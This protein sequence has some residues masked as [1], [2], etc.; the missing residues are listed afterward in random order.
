MKLRILNLSIL[1][2]V[3]LGLAACG[4]NATATAVVGKQDPTGAPTVTTTAAGQ[5][6]TT[7]PTATV[8]ATKPEPSATPTE[9]AP[10]PS[11]TPSTKPGYF[12]RDA[13]IEDARQLAHI[14]E[15]THPD[16]YIRG[17][18]K[19]AFHRRLQRLLNAIP[20]EGMT[21]DAFIQLLRP[22]VAA[23]GDSH[24]ELWSD[25]SVGEGYPNGVPLRF[26]VVEQFLYVKGVLRAEHQHLIGSILVSVEG[27]PVSEL[28][29]RQRELVPLENA[30]HELEEMASHTLWYDPYLRDVLPEWDEEK[31]ITV[32]LQRPTGETEAVTFSLPIAASRTWRAETVVDLPATPSYG[33]QYTMLDPLGTGEE[34]A[35]LRVDHMERFREDAEAVGERGTGIPS[36]TETFRDMV[37]EMAEAGTET[38]IIDLR[39]DHG[40]S[41]LMADIL[42]YFLYGK[43][44]LHSV[45]HAMYRAGGQV[46]RYS[47]QC[48]TPPNNI[49][50]TL[51]ERNAGRAIPIELGGYD[52]RS[53]FAG[54]PDEF[55]QFL[56]QMG[57][58]AFVEW[59][60]STPTFWSEYESE[61]YSG[62]YL[63]ENVV[64][65]TS[66]WTFSS[67]LTM[68]RSLYRV[69]AILVGTPSAQSS[70]SFG[71]GLLWRLDN[72][73]IEGTVTRSYFVIF[74]EDSGLERVLPVHYSLTYDK[75]ASYNF[76]PNAE[77]LY[78]L[79][80]LPEL[81]EIPYAP[82]ATAAGQ[83]P[84]AAPTE[85]AS[86][87]TATPTTR[88]GYFS[89]D[90]LIEDARQLADILESAHPDPYIR[91]GGK[92]AFQYR[93]HRL[94][95][96][97][98]EEGMTRDE[99]V[100]LLRP[101]IAAV[102]D[103]HTDIWDDYRVNDDAPGGVPL[104]F[105][106]VEQSLY[107]AGVPDKEDSD[108]I[109]ALLVSVEGVPLAEL[110]ER[111]TR[112]QG[113]ENE[114]NTLLWLSIF[115][116]WYRPFMEDL[117]P[118]WEDASR[119]SVELQLSTGEIQEFVFDLP[120]RIRR[121]HTS[122]TQVALPST[123]N[124]GFLY[125]FLDAEGKTAY[126][127]VDH[128]SYYREAYEIWALA[129]SRPT[130]EQERSRIRSATET[131]RNLVIEMKAAGTETLIVDLRNNEGGHSLMADILIYFLYSREDFL[132]VVTHTP[133]TGG[134][135]II[136]YS[137]LYFE[138]CSNESI[139][140]Y[141]VERAVP[142]IEGDYC[143]DDDFTDDEEKVRNLFQESETPA[144]VDEWVNRS[145]TFYTEFQ[146]GAYGGYYRP[147]RVVVLVKS[148][149]F[150]SGFTLARYL[151]FAGAT[152]VG[153]PS[154]QA[155][156]C[157]GE[158]NWWVLEHTKIRGGVSDAYFVDFPDDPEVGRV[159]PVHYPL[160]YDKLASYDFDPNAEVLYALELLAQQEE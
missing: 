116:L 2:F 80:L 153:T 83:E 94:L 15:N 150:S 61:A 151:Y 47:A 35:Y 111:Q 97:I 63:P 129:G 3:L 143:F 103:A 113:T 4:G 79:E 87:P 18:G 140:D 13:L 26:G 142:L 85:T 110:Y 124:S 9:V 86:E 127:R 99:F 130:T 19:I 89:R 10:A 146:S 23:V 54:D 48:F 109:G 108:L 11:A 44:A 72:T 141:N 88:P 32:T 34:I 6:P 57:E 119:V 133:A 120:Q 139:E 144:F 71:N 84:S 69:G 77:F 53:F 159:L 155:S 62:Y 75:L 1:L 100:R 126:L 104:R 38:L 138:S 118:E 121:L 149:T 14:I 152:L 39:N 70:N 96:A 117:L 8:T 51:E 128:M 158:I 73:R 91:G 67:G 5:H 58:P 156:N 131:F 59:Y 93:L 147:E 134:G 16:P 81:G 45:K 37:I 49:G 92:V 20:E 24:T 137:H 135:K 74:P 29:A 115:S 82:I 28:L 50:V 21:R 125:D 65:L 36:A 145:P 160:T 157:F 132:A 78:A 7:A 43:E 64:V 123:D 22:F 52:F 42:I 98:P 56:A 95:S 41:S 31:Q 46:D 90:Q 122:E 136:R 106:I 17:G 112:L 66:P 154:A 55:D 25:Y 148:G 68:A 12:S 40:G 33:F 30:Y 60:R 107:V 101:F 76:D 102:G 27:V 105:D 114:Y